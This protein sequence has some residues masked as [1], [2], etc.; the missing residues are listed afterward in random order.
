MKQEGLLMTAN[1]RSTKT[2]PASQ[3]PTTELQWQD[4][5]GVRLR[6]RELREDYVPFID[7]GSYRTSVLCYPTPFDSERITDA[8]SYIV[9]Y[10][11]GT[12]GISFPSAFLMPRDA[13][14]N[15]FAFIDDLDKVRVAQDGRV[16]SAKRKFAE[17]LRQAKRK[18][19][20]IRPV[21]APVAGGE[22]RLYPSPQTRPSLEQTQYSTYQGDS[23]HSA[24][25]VHRESSRGLSQSYPQAV[26]KNTGGCALV[27]TP[28]DRSDCTE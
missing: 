1:T 8:E 28:A 4:A 23:G 15:G 14:G 27:S 20:R 16:E 19:P 18:S 5:G 24:R 12:D 13:A 10:Q 11:E 25:S 22:L 6:D 9:R 7:L 26:H 21:Y 17:E 2:D 3:E